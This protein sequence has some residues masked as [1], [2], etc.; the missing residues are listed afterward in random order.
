LKKAFGGAG[1]QHA[2]KLASITARICPFYDVLNELTVKGNTCL[3]GYLKC[4]ICGSNMT[5][6]EST[7]NGG[8][9]YYYNCSREGKH[10]RCRADEAIHKFVSHGRIETQ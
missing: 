6:A 9:Y 10:F 8:K 7:D 2:T 1:N 5:G 4:P 3:S